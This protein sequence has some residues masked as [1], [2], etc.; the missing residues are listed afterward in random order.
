MKGRMYTTVIRPAL[1]YATE[2]WTV[3]E[4]YK[5]KLRSTEMKMLRMSSGVTLED[6]IRS[7]KIRASAK[8]QTSIEQNM[9][10][11]QLRWYG[12][13]KR[14]D[15]EHIVQEA[16]HF[17]LL[18]TRKRGRPQHSWQRQLEKQQRDYG[19]TDEEIEDRAQYRRRLRNVNTN[20]GR[21]AVADLS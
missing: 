17:E 19:I 16:M 9:K 5:T 1:T 12:H 20:P 7:E 21:P 2:C 8:V 13:V 18:P 6:K 15:S 10:E 11:K 14:R 4:S 3:Y